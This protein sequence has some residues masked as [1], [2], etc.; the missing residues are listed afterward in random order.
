[1]AYATP[2]NAGKTDLRANVVRKE[3]GVIRPRGNKR[4]KRSEKGTKG[5]DAVHHTAHLVASRS[6]TNRRISPPTAT[7]WGGKRLR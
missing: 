5:R 3:N 1:M 2:K 4:R 6:P 7:Q